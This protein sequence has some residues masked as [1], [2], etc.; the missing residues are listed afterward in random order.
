M[1]NHQSEPFV[2]S[3]KGTAREETPQE[4]AELLFRLGYY[5]AKLEAKMNEWA[6]VSNR[7]PAWLS[8]EEDQPNWSVT[9]KG[10]EW[11]ALCEAEFA[12]LRIKD[13]IMLRVYNE[14]VAALRAKGGAA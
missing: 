10:D 11:K 8:V 7:S 5:R 6:E 9:T 4:L 1:A 2:I 13:A 14:T 3:N 12:V